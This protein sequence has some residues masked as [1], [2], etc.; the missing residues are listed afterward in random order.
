MNKILHEQIICAGFGGQGIML[1]GKLLAQIGM[2]AGYNVTWLPSYGAEVRGGTAHS[3][4]HIKTGEIAAPT[5]SKPTTCIVM[6]RPSLIKFEDK[7][8]KNG[9]LIINTSMIDKIVEKKSIKIAGL[10]LTDLA[11]ELGNVRTAN[12]IAIGAYARLRG[13]FSLK[14]ALTELKNMLMA[15]KDIVSINEK[16]I[17]LG[18]DYT[19]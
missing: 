12:M 6:N 3:M 4:T 11:L 7:L 14:Q 5:I 16:A 9:L 19:K 1:M 10:P 15:K 8:E 18:Y 17:K 13:I 2:K